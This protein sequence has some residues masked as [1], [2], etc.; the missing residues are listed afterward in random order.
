[1]QV[2]E[3]LIISAVAALGLSVSTLAGAIAVLWRRSETCLRDRE[4]QAQRIDGLER[5]IYDCP[6]LQCPNKPLWKK[7]ETTSHHGF[8]GNTQTSS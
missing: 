5:A 7:P 1:M 2:P 8:S 3:S 4:L 6:V